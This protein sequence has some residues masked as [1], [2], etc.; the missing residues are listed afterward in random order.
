VAALTQLARIS[1]GMALLAAPA[2]AQS[3]TADL[4]ARLARETD[5]VRRAKVMLPLGEAEF[6]DIQHQIADGNLS[7]ALDILKQYR[8]EASASLKDLDARNVDAERHSGGFKELEISLRQSLRR[9]NEMIVSIT[10]DDQK[11]FVEVRAELEKLNRHLMRELFP[12]Q[13]HAAEETSK[14]KS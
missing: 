2:V 8:D 10:A 1:L 14:P 4:R 13:P 7:D 12:R 6:Q 9:L 11:P 3:H 5:P